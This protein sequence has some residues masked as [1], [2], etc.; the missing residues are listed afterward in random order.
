MNPPERRDSKITTRHLER[1]ACIYIRQSTMKQVQ[2]N[3]ESQVNQYALVQRAQALGWSIA[4]IQVFDGDLGHSGQ[5]S[6]G[7]NDFQE[8]VAQVSLGQVGLI[9]GYE[10][11]RLARNNSDW[12]H[13]LDLAAVFS[14]LIA[15]SD[16]VYDPR[17]Y[18]DRLLLGLKGTMSE[19][20][21]HLLRLR[22]D[23]GRMSQVRRG[24]YIQT[25]PTGL[26]RQ[27][28]GQVVK[29]PDDQVRHTLELV[30]TKFDELG[31]GSR[32]LRY[33]SR[34]KILLPRRQTGGLHQGELLWKR[35]TLSALYEI[36]KN[37]AYA[38]AF[39]HGRRPHDPTRS[40]PGRP[41]TGIVRKPMAEWLHLQPDVYPA[42][43]SWQKY[44]D[45]Q[46][47]L[48]D[49]TIRYN[50]TCGAERGAP[51]EGSALL[52][53][54][55]VCGHCGHRMRMIY[56]PAPRYLCD[57][58][59]QEYGGK[60][61]CYCDA[62]SVDAVVAQAFFEAIQPSQ[63]DALEAV[64]SK[65]QADRAQV[66]RHWQER[67]KRA[68]YEAHLARRQY[69]A[70]DPANR[71][72]AGELE[73]RWDEKL[74]QLHRVQDEYAQFQRTASS[75]A[76]TPE[77]RRQLQQI[78]ET[79][80]N[81][82]QGGRLTSVQKKTLLRSLIARVILKRLA[83]DSIEAKIVWVSGHFTV[84][85][86]RQPVLHAGDV[87]GYAEMVKRIEVLGQQGQTDEAIAAQLTQ[88]GF[89]SARAPEVTVE[90]VHRIRLAHRWF[91]PL[92]QSHGALEFQGYLTATGLARLI[93]V[94]RSWVYRK[95]EHGE[96]DAQFV[97]REPASGVYLIVKDAELIERLRQAVHRRPRAQKGI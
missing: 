3:R 96:I 66:E 64:V 6:D 34:E 52:Q 65:Q 58:L 23:A 51:R 17:L 67:V 39:V 29:D 75:P 61:C 15:D 32:V 5:S 47:R 26:V 84:R 69:E 45:I 24:E 63:L 86:V 50:R 44:L 95:L 27:T 35:P 59:S 77:L 60:M 76:L 7:R 36:L 88:E 73:R 25:L 4:R 13:L 68:E 90:S 30:F 2:N 71:L 28:D 79:L 82:W 33:L 72:V 49:N 22:L 18:N 74:Q 53:G 97:K 81:L 43:I 92:Y 83:P 42:Y 38:G 94:D 12:Y 9:L 37:P 56:K 19:A 16:G 31:S 40:Q 1:K 14:T 11:S 54:L 78:S 8:L 41:A 20:E 70:V 46:A 10:V 21:L 55:V 62:A 89:H 93:D 48:R 87:T 91:R 85:Q 80:P 57:D